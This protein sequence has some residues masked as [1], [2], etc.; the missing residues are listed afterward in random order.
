MRTFHISCFARSTAHVAPPTT[1]AQPLPDCAMQQ[2]FLQEW[3]AH[4]W[5]SS[6]DAFADWFNNRVCK[7][8][9]RVDRAT[10]HGILKSHGRVVQQGLGDHLHGAYY[11]D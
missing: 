9:Y 10:I 2:L 5:R 1:F 3:D 6:S 8:G 4:E 11:R 7:T